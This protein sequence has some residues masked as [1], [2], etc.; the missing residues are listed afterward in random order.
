M[1]ACTTVNV[2][3]ITLMKKLTFFVGAH[4]MRNIF[5]YVCIIIIG[6]TS[7]QIT[8]NLFQIFIMLIVA[9]TA[10]LVLMLILQKKLL[11]SLIKAW[12]S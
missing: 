3:I 12:R 11:N 4:K 7:L 1:F 8:N 6:S 2:E 10:Y 9:L 5:H